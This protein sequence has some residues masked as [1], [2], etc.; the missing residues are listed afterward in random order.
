[1][2]FPGCQSLE[3]DP[4]T[5]EAVYS[6]LLDCFPDTALMM[7]CCGVPALYAGDM[8]PMEEVHRRIRADWNRLGKPVAVIACPACA[9]TFE[10]FLPDIPWTSV[11][12]FIV[13]N[14]LPSD[15]RSGEDCTATRSGKDSINSRSGKDLLN[16]R[17]GKDFSDTRSGQNF[18]GKRWAIFDPCA[19]RKFPDMQ[20]AVRDL[21][22]SMAM[23]FEELPES[24]ARALCCGMGGHIYAANPT[25][26]D[27]MTHAATEQSPL[28][29]L[30]YCSNCRN[31]F[32]FDGKE[33]V[34]VL[35]LLFGIAPQNRPP[36]IGERK[37]NRRRL[38]KTWMS[39]VRN[40]EEP[41]PAVEK[42]SARSEKRVA[43]EADQTG[44]RSENELAREAEQSGIRSKNEL[45]REAEPMKKNAALA[46][47]FDE[48]LL[49]KMD[50]LLISREDVEE[51][52]AFAEAEKLS[53][54]NE[55]TGVEIAHRRLGYITYWVTYRHNGKKIDVL[56]VYSHR[57]RVIENGRE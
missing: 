25:L 11:Y 4:E 29:F 2:F 5:M 56:N 15:A 40:H 57:I 18:P 35:D 43:R 6:Y 54:F 14:G 27:R 31:Q 30:S 38:K 21:C 20:D 46:L 32:L 1:M 3:S 33:T 44:V 12:E 8:E 45:A 24:R 47:R 55:E 16:A 7:A 34:H 39:S 17:S 9:K 41:D 10:E 52:V 36:H 51:T 19:S 50:R 48:T 23:D 28:P 53:V 49:R 37:E 13:K 22:L 42:M 26:T